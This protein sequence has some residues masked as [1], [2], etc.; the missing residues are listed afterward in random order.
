MSALAQWLQGIWWRS[1][2]PPAPLAALTPLYRAISQR[3][4][5]GRRA[6]AQRL[7]V[8]VLVVGNIAVGG[9][10]KTPVTLWLVEQLRELGYRPG[11]LSRGYGGSGPFP[12][13]VTPQSAASAVGDEPLLMAQISGVPLAV[14]PQR[15]QAG[16]ALLAAHPEVN[17]LIC[18]DGLQHY[19]LARD[20]ECAVIDGTR[21]HGNGQL[22]PA[23]PL[24]EPPSRLTQC[25]LL[26][27]NG[28]DAAPYGPQALRFDLHISQARNLATGECRPLSQ[29]AHSPLHAVA[30]IG[31]PE[32]FFSALRA[33]GLNVHSYAFADHHAYQ[34]SDLPAATVLMTEKDAVKCQAFAHPQLWAVPA[35][36]HMAADDAQRV[37]ELLSTCLPPP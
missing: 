37:R 19:A 28:A 32:R 27:V 36:L 29:F 6:S 26:L 23:G 31:N 4:A 25:Q 1:S 7:P 5:Q 33:L 12:A 35:S 15:V 34:P 20:W 11:V 3:I 10:G 21:G 9:T 2:P 17:V 22:L 24:R 30:G 14:A 8:P 18:D 16:Q 13:L